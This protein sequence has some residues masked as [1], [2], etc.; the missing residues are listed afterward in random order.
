VFVCAGDG[1]VSHNEFV[2]NMPAVMYFFYIFK[3][4]GGLGEIRRGGEGGGAWMVIDVDEYRT[5]IP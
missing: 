3:I 1:S 2:Q 5:K 4:I